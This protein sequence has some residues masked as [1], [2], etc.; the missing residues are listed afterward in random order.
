VPVVAC[1]ACLRAPR[2]RE[3]VEALPEAISWH[4]QGLLPDVAVLAA[5]PRTWFV[6][7]DLFAAL[8]GGTSANTISLA[9]APEAP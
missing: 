3:M 4:E 8:A 9:R 5:D 7:T 1:P 2:T 6:Q